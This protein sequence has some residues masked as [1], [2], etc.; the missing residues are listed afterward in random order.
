MESGTGAEQLLFDGQDGGPRE[1]SETQQ[2][3]HDGGESAC[4]LYRIGGPALPPPPRIPRGNSASCE[5]EPGLWQRDLGITEFTTSSKGFK[6]QLKY[7]WRF[8][9]AGAA[10]GF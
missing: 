10:E 5:A 3:P 4:R 6:G 2:L 8:P 1:Y 9:E 7:R